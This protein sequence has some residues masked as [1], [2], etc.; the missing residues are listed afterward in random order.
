MEGLSIL[1][2]KR[3]PDLSKEVGHNIEKAPESFMNIVQ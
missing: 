2:F 3:H 1:I